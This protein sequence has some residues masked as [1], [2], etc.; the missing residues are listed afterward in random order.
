MDKTIET[1]R[2]AVPEQQPRFGLVYY[3]NYYCS[4][5]YY[6][7]HLLLLVLFTINITT[8]T[9]IIVTI[10]TAVTS[11]IIITITLTLL[12]P[13]NLKSQT[14]K[15]KPQLCLSNHFQ[16]RCG[17]TILLENALSLTSKLLRRQYLGIIVG[18]GFRA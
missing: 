10:M 2:H 12:W 13:L 1:A 3:Y 7:D 6:S 8:V 9:S 4:Y 11:C 17:K 16:G 5:R 18:F 15:A 14:P